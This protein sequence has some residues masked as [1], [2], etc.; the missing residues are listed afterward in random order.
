VRCRG[1]AAP[2]RLVGALARFWGLRGHLHEGRAWL[3]GALA[4]GE[5]PPELRAKAFG[6]AATLALR[7]GDNEGLRELARESLALYESVGDRRGMAQ[8]LDRLATGVANGGDLAGSMELYERSLA[9]CREVGEERGLAV[10]TSNMGA[11][12]LMQGDYERVI[13]LCEEGLALYEKRGLRDMMLQPLFNMGV[14]TLLQDRPSEALGFFATALELVRDLDSEVD[15][16]YILTGQAAVHAAL[17]DAEQAATLLGAAQAAAERTGVTL[18]PFEADAAYAA[19]LAAGR[20]LSP[21]DAAA[22][23]TAAQRA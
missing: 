9:L 10:T 6:G 5:G 12:A 18:E 14:A 20:D 1:A 7:R 17:G 4:R 16:M 23:A 13:A 15:L 3:E 8:A 11:L 21:D 2:G 22:Y 19:A